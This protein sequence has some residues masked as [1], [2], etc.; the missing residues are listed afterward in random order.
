MSKKTKNIPD[1]ADRVYVSGFDY[2]KLPESDY[3]DTDPLPFGNKYQEEIIQEVIAEIDVP[4]FREDLEVIREMA[5]NAKYQHYYNKLWISKVDVKHPV[6]KK[7][8]ERFEFLKP[9]I[10]GVV[11]LK[12]H[13]HEYITPHKDPIR[14]TS[15]YLPLFSEDEYP[16]LEIYHNDERYG[17]TR[18]DNQG[19]YAW[20]PKK[21][22]AVFNISKNDRYNM[23]LLLNI[24][25]KQV[26]PLID[27]ELGIRRSKDSY[28]RYR[29]K[30][31]FSHLIPEWED[32]K[33]LD[34]GCNHA[35][36]LKF[37]P[38]VDYDYTGVD[39]DKNIIEQCKNEYP[40]QKWLS[41]ETFNWQYSASRKDEWPE[42]EKYDYI[43]AFSVYTHTD[44]AS[45]LKDINRLKKHLHPGG[46]I[47]CTFF[48]NTIGSSWSQIVNYRYEYFGK[49]DLSLWTMIEQSNTI[50][51]SVRNGQKQIF[52]NVTEIPKFKTDY[53]VTYYDDKYLEAITGG[54][55]IDV[56]KNYHRGIMSHQKCLVI[57]KE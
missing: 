23:Q 13:P 5:E 28:I 6:I 25:Y 57:E 12:F 17:V 49:E 47:M 32:K 55:V 29:V 52:R 33:I 24:P 45:F 21:I 48:S 31:Y 44:L 56:N 3:K 39:I 8:M 2:K 46:K 22:H 53:F 1:N 41:Y 9:Y 35:N 50:S 14:Q 11:F 7:Y 15:I 37:Y 18:N 27:K 42:L 36:F 4:T 34:W 20:N 16:P 40:E 30:N 19:F 10:F 51:F 38:K 26:I 54:K 43:L